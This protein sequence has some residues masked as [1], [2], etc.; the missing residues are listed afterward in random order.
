[1]EENKLT[2]N[3]D[4]VIKADYSGLWEGIYYLSFFVFF[5]LF[6]LP[7][8]PKQYSLNHNFS[9]AGILYGF[10][11]CIAGIV[12]YRV[13]RDMPVWV[14]SG[15]IFIV[16]ALVLYQLITHADSFTVAR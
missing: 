13:V 6:I 12:I 14:K 7:L 4:T 11:G 10:A 8:V 1:M 16:Y 3:E 15:I 9:V 2:D 5:N